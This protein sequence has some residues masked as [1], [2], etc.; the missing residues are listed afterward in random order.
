MKHLGNVDV[1]NN[2]KVTGN[3]KVFENS[4]WHT[5]K[6][7]TGSFNDLTGVPSFDELY[8][9]WKPPV[10]TF[11]DLQDIGLYI[12]DFQKEEVTGVL[13]GD[14]GD[15]ATLSFPATSEDSSVVYYLNRTD[16]TIEFDSSTFVTD[17]MAD[18]NYTNFNIYNDTTLLS[19]PSQQDLEDLF[20]D[21]KLLT[22]E[23]IDATD[24]KL[25]LTDIDYE[26]K[27]FIHLSSSAIGSDWYK[28]DSDVNQNSYYEYFATLNVSDDPANATE[29]GDVRL[30]VDENVIYIY[31]MDETEDGIIGTDYTK[32]TFDYDAGDLVKNNTDVI[33]IAY[34]GSFLSFTELTF[35][36]AITDD[37]SNAIVWFDKVNA[38]PL[39][40]QTDHSGDSNFIKLAELKPVGDPVA[41]YEYDDTKEVKIGGLNG[42]IDFVQFG[43]VNSWSEILN[44]P[45][46]PTEFSDLTD[47]VNLSNFNGAWGNDL[48]NKPTLATSLLKDPVSDTSGLTALDGASDNGKIKLNL[49]N[50]RL[51][52]YKHGET[53]QNIFE[54]WIPIGNYQDINWGTITNIPLSPS[55]TADFDSE[56][57]LT[58]DI[59]Y[60]AVA[61]I[62]L[63]SDI[64]NALTNKHEHLN[65]D[66]LN[67]LPFDSGD[68]AGYV[69][70]VNSTADGF[71]FTREDYFDGIEYKIFNIA[72]TD[73]TDEGDSIYTMVLNHGLNT[74]NVMTQIYSLNSS[75][76]WVMTTI[77]D[78]TNTDV[79]NITL[80]SIDNLQLKVMVVTLD[81]ES[82][83]D[84]E[85]IDFSNQ[86]TNTD[87]L[88]EILDTE[89]VT[90]TL[91]D[92]ID[93]ITHI[94][95]MQEVT[96]DNY[97]DVSYDTN[98]TIEQIDSTNIKI[99][100]NS[101]STQKV[102][103][104]INTP[105]IV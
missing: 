24:W 50:G 80:T 87:T 17:L 6:P 79:N 33:K 95:L 105:S 61:N 13:T 44:K 59:P 78:V 26:N 104:T 48:I 74:T 9:N 12:R 27:I 57:D 7:F 100:N 97:K 65:S 21:G 98:Y 76:E 40:D 55:N 66:L 42:W 2:I 94:T 16:D 58:K 41:T 96:T 28:L 5:L 69:L 82:S 86:Y 56:V 35:D 54:G 53:G 83:Y 29:D 85:D 37:T 23:K 88:F 31:S 75:S 19:S 102:F 51:Y 14:A 25:T 20:I 49:N 90:I 30:V 3:L 36:S 10:A 67:T 60:D 46:I 64:D 18:A 38:Y 92:A 89:S 22:I 63:D 43:G 72:D 39:I 81:V 103:V 62:K 15:Y 91:T 84:I 45:L 77:D 68:K 34:D 52:V 32:L 73:W 71:E 99:T 11:T 93:S 70:K 47:D 1:H 101:G 4:V 8:S